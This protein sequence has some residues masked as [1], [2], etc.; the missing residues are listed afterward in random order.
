MQKL[1][2][3]ALNQTAYIDSIECEENIKRRLLELGLIQGTKIQPVLKSALGD[4]TAYEIRGTLISIRNEE[5]NR[6]IV[7]TR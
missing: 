3:I 6:I 1:G 2:Q 4:P 7:K 5:A